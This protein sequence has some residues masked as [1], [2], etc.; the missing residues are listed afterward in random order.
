MERVT[1]AETGKPELQDLPHAGCPFT[2][3]SPEMLQC[4]DVLVHEKRH[5]MN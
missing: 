2:A 5:I 1:A 3:V 4:A